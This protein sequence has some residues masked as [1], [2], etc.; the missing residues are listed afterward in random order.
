MR[1]K[2]FHVVNNKLINNTIICVDYLDHNLCLY[3]TVYLNKFR[4]VMKQ[5]F[6]SRR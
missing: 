5:Q 3:N 2:C 4:D 1:T 6:A